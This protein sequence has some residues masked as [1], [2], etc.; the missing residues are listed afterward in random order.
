VETK[1]N[2]RTRERAIGEI[3]WDMGCKSELS[4]IKWAPSF[5]NLEA[6]RGGRAWASRW[7]GHISM[8]HPIQGNTKWYLLGKSLA[9]SLVES[10]QGHQ[11]LWVVEIFC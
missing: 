11:V 5:I 6:G 4:R 2:A 1:T 7:C 3:R 10:C 8:W 9:L